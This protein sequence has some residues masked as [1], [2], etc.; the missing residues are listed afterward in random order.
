MRSI[1]QHGNVRFA[2]PPGWRALP[3]VT[4][5]AMVLGVVGYLACFIPLPGIA[6]LTMDPLSVRSGELWRLVTY[7]LCV[8]GIWNLLFALLILWSCGAELELYWGS[9]RYAVFLLSA[10]VAGGVLGT[11][12]SFLSRGGGGV[13]HGPGGLVTA[14]IVGWALIGPRMPMTFWGVLPMSRGVFAIIALVIAFFGTFEG[15]RSLPLLGCM[16]GGVPIAWLFSRRGA[17]RLAGSSPIRFPRVFRRR[18]FRVVRGSGDRGDD[19]FRF[20]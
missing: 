13:G 5:I 9:R 10:A 16:L 15:S 2:T 4:R 12:L 14:V 20:H 19:G 6:S 11:L 7:P 3:L 17:P 1:G 18:R 8:L